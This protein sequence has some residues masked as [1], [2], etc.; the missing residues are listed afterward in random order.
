M[1]RS[2]VVALGNFS[3][4]PM[5]TDYFSIPLQTKEERV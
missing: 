3:D 1:V 5:A 4:K 2:G